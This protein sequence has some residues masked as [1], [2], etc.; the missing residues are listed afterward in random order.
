MKL[1]SKEDGESEIGIHNIPIILT[2]SFSDVHSLCFRFRCMIDDGWWMGTVME[3]GVKNG[4][5]SNVFDEVNSHFLSLRVR[6]DN[7]EYEQMSPWDLEPIDE[8]S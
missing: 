3:G 5:D 6:W 7:G 2:Y 1:P 8:S 4:C